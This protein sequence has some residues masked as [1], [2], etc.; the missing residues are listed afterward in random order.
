MYCVK[1][2]TDDLAWIGGNDR[3]LALFE[4]VYGVPDGVSYNSYFIDD[5]KTVVMDTV[6][7]AVADLFFENVDHMLA[8]RPLDYLVVD[9]M[10]PDHAATIEGLVMRH[11]EVTVVCNAKIQTMIRQYF[12]FDI[13]SRVHVV[14]EGDVLS[15]GRHQLTFVMAPMVHW[16]EVMVTYDLTDKILFS[17]DAFG[18]FGALNGHIFADEVDFFGEYLD[19][20]RRYYCNIVGKYGT[21][22]MNLLKKAANLDL[23]LVC[24][25]H[26]FVWRRGVGDFVEKYVKWASYQPEEEGVVIAYASVYGHTAN[27][28]NILAAKLADRGMRVKMYDVSMTHS[29]YVVADCFKYSHLVFCST[30]YNAGIFIAMEELLNDIAAHN[31][32]NRTVAFIENGSWAPTSGKLMR[33]I[34]APLKNMALIEGG[35]TLKSTLKETQLA[36]IDALADAI[37]ATLS[38]PAA[39]AEVASGEVDKGAFR[40]LTYGLFILTAREGDKD[41][42]CVINTLAQITTSPNRISICVN[43]G[44]LTHDMILRTGVFNV[45]VLTE[46]APFS[47]Y[48]HFGFQTGRDTDKFADPQLG[49]RSANGLKYLTENVNSFVSGKVISAQDYGTHT[50]FIADVTEA[51]TLSKDA[52]VTYAYYHAHV[53]PR[54]NPAPEKK[55]GFVCTVCGYVY[56]GDTLP[57]DFICPLCKHPASDFEPIQ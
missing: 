1:K 40:N 8:G 57:E 31:L 11:P 10:E 26:G 23:Q 37:A 25:L 41:N 6:D 34:L 30:T 35:V 52:S 53:K 15:T 13:D 38:Q 33:E 27:V 17:A 16:P 49:K 39:P 12:N 18:T 36:Q 54:S 47:L 3:R 44:G 5:E 19:E 28:A 50:L 14:K 4:G 51:Q 29:S 48:Q 45:S 9:H 21:Q 55:K 20:A 42:G 32:Q 24:P 46:K 2:I 43:K 22:V 56:E 7:L